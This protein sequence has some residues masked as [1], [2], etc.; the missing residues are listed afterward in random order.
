M[1]PTY[2]RSACRSKHTVVFKL[3]FV[4]FFDEVSHRVLVFVRDATVVDELVADEYAEPAVWIV[5]G[6]ES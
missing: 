4:E 2:S 1:S 3:K 5:L 6:L